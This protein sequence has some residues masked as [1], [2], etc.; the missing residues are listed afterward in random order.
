MFFGSPPIF[1][2]DL[3]FYKNLL[4]L[5]LKMPQKCRKYE[6]ERNISFSP[7]LSIL[8]I[9]LMQKPHKECKT[10]KSVIYAFLFYLW[11]TG[12]KS[13][14]TPPFPHPFFL[15]LYTKVFLVST[16]R[17]TML[18]RFVVLKVFKPGANKSCFCEIC[19]ERGG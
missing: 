13:A 8:H 18:L 7:F 11:N 6:K 16:N 3:Q 15:K 2:L 5:K 9:C 14:S 10:N 19:A 4:S 17:Y 12:L 1:I